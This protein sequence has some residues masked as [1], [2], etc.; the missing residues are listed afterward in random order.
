MT[1][2]P[3]RRKKREMT[4][5]IIVLRG[6]MGKSRRRKTRPPADPAEIARRAYETRRN[7][8]MWGANEDALKLENNRDVGSEAETRTRTRRIQRFD[9]FATLN[10]GLPAFQAVRRYQHD[11]AEANGVGDGRDTLGE[12]VDGGGSREIVTARMMAATKRV[13]QLYAQLTAPDIILLKELSYPAWVKGEQPNWHA[14]LKKERGVIDR[15]TQARIVRELSEAV[16]E[17]YAEIDNGAK[18]AA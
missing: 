1:T 14:V 18:R 6:P 17:G 3:Q 2:Q 5:S 4:A 11:L 9:C 12:Y 10:I 15:G 16:R 8:A 13:F 7:P